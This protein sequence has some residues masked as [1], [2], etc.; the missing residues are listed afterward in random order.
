MASG[1][2]RCLIGGAVAAMVAVLGGMA[3]PA[4]TPPTG[5][6]GFTLAEA[7]RR[8]LAYYP[9]ALVA[10]RNLAAARAQVGV[11]RTSYLPVSGITAQ[12]DRGTDNAVLGPTFPSP[13]PAISGTVP[14][15][16]YFGGSAWTSAAGVYFNWELF[17]FGRRAANVNFYR[18]LA[19]QASQQEQYVRLQVAAHAADTF[20]NVL[21][22]QAE[23]QV[24]QADVSRWHT[25][26]QIVRVLVAQQLRPG[27]DASRAD[28][29]LAGARIR[30]AGTV[31]A[32]ARAQAALAEA[33]GNARA[34]LP[35]LDAGLLAAAPST[36]PPAAP[37]VA[38]HPQA[39]AQQQA[40]AA[41]QQ[42]GKELAVADRPRLYLL[43]AA[44]GRGT[45]VVAPGDLAAG[46]TGL[47]PTGA[48][49]WAVGAG[50]AFSFTRL[51][52]VRRQR[53]VQRQQLAAAQ[54]Q[55]ALAASTYRRYAQ[56]RAEQAVSPYEMEQ[57]ATARQSRQALAAAARAQL[58]AAA[59]QLGRARAGLAQSEIAAG[60]G[61]VRAPFAGRITARPAAVGDLA[62]PGQ[63]LYE[64]AG[65]A[66][67]K[68]RVSVPDRELRWIHLGERVRVTGGAGDGAPAGRWATVQRMAPASDAATHMA[69]V[70]LRLPA[71]GGWRP[72]A[73]ATA[74]FPLAATRQLW[75]PSGAV[76]RAGGL[77]EVYVVN[78]QGRA[79][80]RWVRTGREAAGQVEILAGLK[81]SETVV[82]APRALAANGGSEAALAA[83]GA[84]PKG[85][86]GHD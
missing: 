49:N 72:G 24:A 23:Q 65:A 68:L 86:N 47:S 66:G 63:P 69:V 78:R 18:D 55:A 36:A 56:L 75:L 14:T 71:G 32:V 42:Q 17:D 37:G 62:M 27:A 30:L 81:G 26:D 67:S 43:G 70:E 52:Q 84:A 1:C 9:G 34:V 79:E 85:A 31:Q 2:R 48:G 41:S 51:A 76:L 46:A 22:A 13:L 73:F 39:R 54:A 83:A 77:S 74:A 59:A 20:L 80:L 57:V 3:R 12:F 21:A 58:Q 8:A 40:V 33:V 10:A 15:K 6:R 61:R 60:Y 19:A 45:G 53:A 16:D 82:A 29:E 5:R 38:L 35:A 44:Y 50:L 25:V 7:V 4:A 64:L 11:A 28:A